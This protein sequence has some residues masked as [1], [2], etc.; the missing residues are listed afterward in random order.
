[1]AAVTR[2][3]TGTVYLLHFAAPIGNPDNPRGAAQHYMGWT[4]YLGPRLAA[5]R[6]GVGAAIMRAVAEEGI[7]F[8]LARTWAG[9]RGDERRLKD[10]H[11]HPALCPVCRGREPQLDPN[12]KLV[13]IE[14]D[15]GLAE[16]RRVGEARRQE[17]ANEQAAP[18]SRWAAPAPGWGPTPQVE[19]D[20]G[21]AQ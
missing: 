1:V 3:R 2:P 14:R 9:S 4:T 5:H 21:W 15:L 12:T 17:L 11:D 20:R 16:L 18:A 13:D 19:L 8:T 7:D 10:R 6:D